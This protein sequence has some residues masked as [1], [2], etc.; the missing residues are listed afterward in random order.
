MRSTTWLTPLSLVTAVVLVCGCGGSGSSTDLLAAPQSV[1]A[2][3][4]LQ[5]VTLTWDEVPGA[6]SYNVYLAASPVLTA[7]NYAALPN[8]RRIA[9]IASTSHTETGLPFGLKV[10]GLVT[11]QDAEGEGVASARVFTTTAPSQPRFLD[12]VE[13]LGMVTLYWQAPSHADGF[14]VYVA[15]DPA[16]TSE[17]FASLPGGAVA[18]VTG[19]SLPLLGLTNDTT[20]YLVV[21]AFNA[22]G[23]GPDSGVVPATPH[24]PGTFSGVEDI[25]T[26]NAPGGGASADFDE[27]GMIDLAVPNHDD[28]TVSVLLGLGGGHF[29]LPLDLAVGAGPVAV[30]AADFDGDGHADLAAANQDDGTVSVLHGLGD[31]T[32]GDAQDFLAGNRPSALVA[33]A[34]VPGGFLDLA[35]AAEDDG[36]VAVLLGNGDGTFAD[37]V[38]YATGT[39]P[40][41]VAVG[42]LDGDFVLDLVVLNA[43]DGSVSVLLGNGDGT[44]ADA[45]NAP[46][47]IKPNSLALSDMDRDG[48]LDVAVT[49]SAIGAVSI[50][51]GAGDG[52]LS[53]SPHYVPTMGDTPSAV[54]VGDFFNG[55]GFPDLVVANGTDGTVSVFLGGAH[56]MFAY[57]MDLAAGTEPSSIQVVDFDGDGVLDLAV[58][59][60]SDGTV[61]IFLG[62]PH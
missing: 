31:G 7:S 12:A 5:D 29:A 34:F 48:L 25:T 50:L 44:F 47:G 14:R 37:P 3:A 60:R 22:A 21:T 45:Q 53:G 59:T 16:I 49:D 2:N 23:E 62:T 24:G 51:V 18:T 8:R 36:A 38:A 52:S 30:V 26:G 20:Y 9:G 11:A 1:V 39:G 27:D 57:L 42:T 58:T 56:G 32:F 17:N 33:A 28:A 54:A 55:D 35:V 6:T 46:S 10:Y 4:V 61:R 41:A 40:T 43:G 13:G 15:T 19:P